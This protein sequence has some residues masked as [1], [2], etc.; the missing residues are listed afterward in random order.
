M[1]KDELAAAFWRIV[2][3]EEL[4]CD[5]HR[6]WSRQFD[7]ADVDVV[8]TRS[9]LWI[10]LGWGGGTSVAFRAAFSPGAL[11]VKRCSV[12]GESLLI[13]ADT[14][15]G[16]QL[17]AIAFSAAA[18]VFTFR[19]SV[20]PRTHLTFEAWSR[21]IVPLTLCPPV[22]G[23]VHSTAD[24]HRAGQLHVSIAD[25][26]A[27]LYLQE[28]PSLSAFCDATRAPSAQGVGG[29]WPDV[30]FVLPRGRKA[31]GPNDGPTVLSHAHV[32]WNRAT[33]ADP[34]DVVEQQLA[35]LAA[36]YLESDRRHSL[37]GE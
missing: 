33:P 18:A 30:G 31:L 8:F 13:E 19:T 20:V 37:R 24:D 15:L 12:E 16:R 10:L 22:D 21:D 3:I 26:G 27:F 29:E 5:R 6:L 14:R 25:V 4:L 9:G 17:C 11:S 23:R 35:L 28:L 32:A 1:R 34:G 7:D 2:Q 36:I